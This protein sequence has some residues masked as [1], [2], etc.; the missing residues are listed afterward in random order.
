VGLTALGIGVFALVLWSLVTMPQYNWLVGIDR[1]IYHDAALRWIGGGFWYYP[2]QV[3]GPYV[4]TTGHVLYPPVAM[5][6]LVPAAFLPDPLWW[7]IPI[8]VT[9]AIVWR[10]R[11]APWT[12]PLMGACLA[13]NVTAQFTASGNP[14]LWIMMFIAVGTLWRPAFALVLLKPSLF[15][16]ALF[17]IRDRG[18]WVIVAGF[19]VL[20]FVTL[21]MTLDYARVLLNA[22]GPVASIFYSVRDLPLLVIPLIAW[23]GRTVDREVRA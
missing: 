13:W 14:S 7:A 2:E 9:A 8:C 21:P 18:W 16:L 3:A 17:G 20:T 23:R 12:W 19:A 15:P 11:P 4:L 22:R 1:G 10:H 6:W 5:L